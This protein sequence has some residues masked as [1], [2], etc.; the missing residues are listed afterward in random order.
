MR[1]RKGGIDGICDSIMKRSR[2]DVTSQSV[3][4]IWKSVRF[5]IAG[6][7]A[8]AP[9]AAFSSRGH[10]R[11]YASAVLRCSRAA[12]ALCLPG[13]PELSSMYL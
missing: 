9:S 6:I 4:R 10:S 1:I 2:S 3:D 5:A 13:T 8:A 12:S 11:R 7:A